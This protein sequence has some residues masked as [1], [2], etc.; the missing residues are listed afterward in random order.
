MRL[1]CI[2]DRFNFIDFINAQ[3]RLPLSVVKERIIIST[4]V[5]WLTLFELIKHSTQALAVN[6]ASVHCKA[7]NVSTVLIHYDHDPMAFHQNGF[8]AKQ[9]Y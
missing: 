7:D 5:G 6:S 2:R 9:I 8:T 3:I 4:E 1:R